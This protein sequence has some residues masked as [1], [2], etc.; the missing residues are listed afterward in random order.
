MQNSRRKFL[1]NVGL[2][3]AGVSLQPKVLWSKEN[4]IA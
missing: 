1:Q 2:A 4:I 3:I